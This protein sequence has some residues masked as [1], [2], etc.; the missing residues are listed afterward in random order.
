MT[1]LSL[2]AL[3]SLGGLKA[4]SVVV[5]VLGDLCQGPQDRISGR[6]LDRLV[7]PMGITNQTLR[8]AL[9]RLRRDGWIVSEKAGRS[10][11]YGLTAQG[12][13]MTVAARPVV[14]PGAGGP[15]PGV[16]LA[17]APPGLSVAEFAESLPEEAVQLSAR[18]ALIAG[19]GP[20][21]DW[22]VSPFA[23]Q[24]LPDWVAAAL[25]P[26]DLVAEYAAL[27]GAVPGGD[28]PDAPL[29]RAVLR[30]LILHLWRRLRLRHGPLPDLLL[31]G[32]AGAQA[33]D[34][35][36]PA[37]AALPR[38]ALAELEALA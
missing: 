33:R 6:L 10:S 30:L 8:V 21:E 5:T 27:A 32:W 13:A 3:H 29:D 38:P 36:A 18:S 35:V 1:T 22:L 16:S 9:H 15:A 24:A 17:I 23:A 11:N 19:G 31:P 4:W 26:P 20:G 28:W 37:L 25:A 7:G 14:Y 12:W 2:S 34:R